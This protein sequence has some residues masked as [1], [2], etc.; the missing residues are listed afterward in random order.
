MASTSI[1]VLLLIWVILTLVI[2]N[3]SPYVA[4]QIQPASSIQTVEREKTGIEQ[5]ISRK[6]NEEFGKWYQEAQKK[7]VPFEEIVEKW[8]TMQQEAQAEIDQ[9]H[10]KVDEHFK[11]GLDAQIV[12]AKNLS[13]AS[14]L[15]PFVYS[16]ADISDT[17]VKERDHFL[18][19]LSL[20]KDKWTQYVYSKITVGSVQ[21]GGEQFDTSDY[22]K[23][24]YE[25]SPL[26]DRIKGIFTDLL[27][28]AV[29]NILFFMGAYLSF[30]RY[31]VR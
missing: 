25:E 1:T 15:S 30:L 27:I 18:K 13:K 22:P 24:I 23:F 14:P 17:G 28:L 10:R 26:N 8:K 11:R 16:V 12:L 4:S 29:W 9:A 20:Y 19:T 5:E 3:L 2:P 6:N 7:N 31:D 21:G